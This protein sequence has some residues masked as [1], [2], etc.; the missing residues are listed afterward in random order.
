[1]EL[2]EE[3]MPVSRTRPP[4]RFRIRIKKTRDIVM[5]DLF[6]FLDARGNMTNNCL[7][8]NLFFS[9]VSFLNNQH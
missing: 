1:M 2:E 9:S 3:N 6:Q 7:M 8:G 4:Q 5:R